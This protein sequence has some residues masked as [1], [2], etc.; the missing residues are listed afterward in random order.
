MDTCRFPHTDKD[1]PDLEVTA[2]LPSNHE[3]WDRIVVPSVGLASAAVAGPGGTYTAAA[4]QAG[5]GGR[6]LGRPLAGQEEKIVISFDWLATVS[7]AGP[8]S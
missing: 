5:P 4:L 1:M 7:S 2:H 3:L 6:R 8:A